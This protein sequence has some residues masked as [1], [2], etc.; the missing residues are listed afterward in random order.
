M[1]VIIETTVFSFPPGA[2]H[3]IMMNRAERNDNF[4]KIV[5]MK[6]KID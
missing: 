4:L 3:E 5:F 2:L 6:L 1:E